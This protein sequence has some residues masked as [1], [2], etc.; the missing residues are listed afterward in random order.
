[1]SA[2]LQLWRRFALLRRCATGL[3]RHPDG[4]DYST[5]SKHDQE[6]EAGIRLRVLLLE[7]FALLHKL[8]DLLFRGWLHDCE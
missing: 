5:V 8:R 1:M 2:A 7:I 3:S 4:G 6:T